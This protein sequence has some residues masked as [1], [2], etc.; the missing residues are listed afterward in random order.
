MTDSINDITRIAKPTVRPLKVYAF[1]PSAGHL[2][3]N[4]MTSLVPYER[5]HPGPVGERFA[6][7]DYDGSRKVY[8]APIDLDNPYITIRGGLDPTETDPRFHQ[9]MVYAVASETLQRFEIAL[10]RRVHWARFDQAAG[11][12]APAG[13]NVLYLYP[14]AM[15]EANAFYSR[16]AQGILFG[17][18]RASRTHPGPNLPGQTVFTCLSHDIIAHETTHAVVDGIR[19]FFTEPTNIDVPAFHEAFADLSALFC[20]FSHKEALLD[21]LQKTGGRLFQYDLRTEVPADAPNGSGA[22]GKPLIQGQLTQINPLVQLAQQFGEASG[23]RGGLRSAL[24]TPPN[25]DDIKSKI[26]P[27]DRGSILVAAVFDAYF[28]I[29][30]RR[31]ADLFRIYRA[32]GGGQNPIDLPQPL[33]DRLAEAA[34]AT[35]EEFF[36]ICARALDYC[37]PVDIVFGDF[38]RAILTAHADLHP[39]DPYGVRNAFMQAFRLRGIV[40]EDASFF[41]ENSLCWPQVASGKLPAVK[42]LIFG[43]PNGLTDEEKNT[44]GDVLRAYAKANATKLGFPRDHGKIDVPSFHPMFRVGPYGDLIIDMVVE[45]VETIEEKDAS[46]GA[47]K[48]RSGVTLL[49][50]QEKLKEGERPAPHIHYVIP[51][52]RS[53]LR[54]ERQH[55]YFTNMPQAGRQDHEHGHGS[56]GKSTAKAHA[57]DDSD[58]RWR[59]DF[60][61]VHLG[62]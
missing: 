19:G 9:Q 40:P 17:Y 22:D 30:T 48:F 55:D 37:P 46:L 35:A 38:L 44:N 50:W 13:R 7:V 52:H 6:V 39:P 15:A 36:G 8:Y 14:H 33:A 58:A 47:Y 26:E 10:G 31:T 29:Y 16:D 2:V 34:S 45:L 53:A 54:A 23:M 21:T 28:T 51:K 42:G 3:G 61:L 25:S 57:K 59:I 12:A 18:F 1:D 20:H 32:G 49:I 5:L 56:D 43:D 62:L 60:G 11:K 41:S 24:G 27:H 4:H